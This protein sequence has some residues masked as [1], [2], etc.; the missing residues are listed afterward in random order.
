MKDLLDVIIKY[1][2]GVKFTQHTILIE[3]GLQYILYIKIIFFIHGIQ[4]II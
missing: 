4:A 1:Y 3:I 2:Y